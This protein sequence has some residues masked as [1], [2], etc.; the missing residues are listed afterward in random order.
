MFAILLI[1]LAAFALAVFFDKKLHETLPAALIA[2]T[3]A[4][5]VFALL[6][7]LSAAVWICAGIVAV[8][9]VISII[10]R[11]KI[12]AKIT[13]SRIADD[14]GIISISKV[15]SPQ[16]LILFAAC[17]LFCIL[18]ANRRVFFYD[19]LSY[20][21][22][23]T[24]NIFTID[25]LPHLYE[26]C[27]VH[28]KDYTPIIQILQY[29]ALFGRK[30]FTE[31]SLF[32]TNVCLIY[33]LLLPLINVVDDRNRSRS[34]RIAATVL[35][36][37]FPHILTSQFYTRLGVDLFLAL[38]L[39]YVICCVFFVPAEHT[40]KNSSETFRLACICLGVAFLSL[41]KSS[42]IVLSIMALVMFAV[43]ELCGTKDNAK[44]SVVKTAIVAVFAF[45]SYFSWQLFLRYSGN[46]GYLTDRVKGSAGGVTLPSYTG[47]VILN[48]IKHF[49]TYPLTRNA[50]GITAAA[51]VVFI[52]IVHIL[53]RRSS[54]NLG[55]DYN[56]KADVIMFVSSMTGLVLFCIAHIAMYLFV[57]DEWEAH[58]LLEY[59]RYITQYLG[60]IF[61]VYCVKLIS[62]AALHNVNKEENMLKPASIMMYISVAAFIA[63][64]PYADM[65]MLAPS[66]YEA[67][68][69]DGY[70]QMSEKAQNEWD[71]SGISALGLKRDGSERLTVLA[72]EWDETTQ[73]MEYTFVPQP[74]YNILNVPAVEPGSIVSYTESGFMDAYLYVAEN[75]P[76][77][78]KGDWSETSELTADG[79][80]LEGATL[81]RVVRS[82]DIK[83]LE[84]VR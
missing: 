57:F 28:Y 53:L 55:S 65:K 35:Y 37:I 40:D 58:G 46:R 16:L 23:Y 54:A 38:S 25:R 7:P 14:H 64:L 61:M 4:V 60:G 21:G 5:Y 29:I 13:I 56:R 78:Y 1:L 47:E 76:G 52:I 67:M 10:S 20:W 73:F 41:I 32:Q 74:I 81:Y 77:S 49:F 34:S 82:N 22:I 83:Y 62:V 30:S 42:G 3:L 66:T 33:I 69:N 51:V 2:V 72:D 84:P 63:L 19:D 79:T 6:L 39:G 9:L 31:G 80:A 59:D 27:S 11:R 24:K 12:D 43:Y 17:T 70:A 50:W 45:G 48:Y 15:L 36:V 44:L 18:F 71:S 68:F 8:T 26:N 75:A